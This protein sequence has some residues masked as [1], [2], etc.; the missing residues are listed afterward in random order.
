MMWA[1]PTYSAS[2]MDRELER[3]EAEFLGMAIMHLESV[4]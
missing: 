1:F 3:S 4:L 2:S